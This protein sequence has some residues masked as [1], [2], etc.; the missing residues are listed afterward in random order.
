MDMHGRDRVDINE[1][2][3]ALQEC[4]A[5]VPSHYQNPDLPSQVR[6]L[7]TADG[8]CVKRESVWL[9]VCAVGQR[10]CLSVRP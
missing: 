4:E 9:C 8:G 2:Y 5:T 6:A 7:A 3:R 1:F 10:V